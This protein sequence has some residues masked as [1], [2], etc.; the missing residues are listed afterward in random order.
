MKIRSLKPNEKLLS[1]PSVLLEFKIAKGL[2][3]R[4]FQLRLQGRRYG[5]LSGVIEVVT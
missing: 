5:E 3:K 4:R 2:D 1:A